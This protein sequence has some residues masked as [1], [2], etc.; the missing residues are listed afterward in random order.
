MTGVVMN[1]PNIYIVTEWI[2]GGSLVEL[3]R[4]PAN[5][6]ELRVLLSFALQVSKGMEYVHEKNIIHRDLAARNVLCSSSR[7][8]VC[9]W[10][11][12]IADFGE[13]QCKQR[14]KK[15]R[16]RGDLTLFICKRIVAILVQ[17]YE[18]NAER[19]DSL[20]VDSARRA[21]RLS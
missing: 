19:N 2:D 7:D 9:P 10:I 13:D 8:P 14:K 18:Q 5:D 15:E 20:F 3:L 21:P 11:L 4:N 6:P 17:G 1:L 12:K 16:E